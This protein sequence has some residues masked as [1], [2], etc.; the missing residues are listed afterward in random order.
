MVEPDEDGKGDLPDADPEVNPGKPSRYVYELEEGAVQEV[1]LHECI[2]VAPAMKR[3]RD[4][5]L[6]GFAK[7]QN[8]RWLNVTKAMK[9]YAPLSACDA[10]GFD[11]ACERQ[12]EAFRWTSVGVADDASSAPPESSMPPVLPESERAE[13]K[14]SVRFIAADSSTPVVA[15]AKT[16]I[17]EYMVRP[18]NPINFGPEQL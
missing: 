4:G 1:A 7:A 9:D 14:G 15:F 3:Y 13:M 18:Q 5:F 10:D 6:A 12:K 11:A 8:P 16:L 17:R 2:G